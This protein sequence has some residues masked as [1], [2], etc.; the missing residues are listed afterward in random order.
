MYS[1]QSAKKKN[2]LIM[3]QKASSQK[4]RTNILSQIDYVEAILL[5]TQTALGQVLAQ[6]SEDKTNT[7][8]K[9]EFGKINTSANIESDDNKIM[10]FFLINETETDEQLKEEILNAEKDSSRF[11]LRKKF[12]KALFNFFSAR[13]RRLRAFDEK[14]KSSSPSKKL[15]LLEALS[16]KGLLQKDLYKKYAIEYEYLKLEERTQRMKA[17]KSV[18]AQS[19]LSK[20]YASLNKYDPKSL[21]AGIKEPVVMRTF[22]ESSE[23]DENY[24]PQYFNMPAVPKQQ[25]HK[26]LN[27]KRRT[28]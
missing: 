17:L 13:E 6:I 21:K 14:Y 18:V 15:A 24:K 1:R 20:K 25:Q 16:Q 8:N 19:I 11:F 12:Y 23:E 27:L 28:N 26:L 7:L 10:E 22:E 3:L 4:E 9:S 2:L 5:D